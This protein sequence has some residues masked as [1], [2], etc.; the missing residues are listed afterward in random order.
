MHLGIE[1][2]HKRD[3]LTL[4]INPTERF[5]K[6]HFWKSCSGLAVFHQFHQH[7]TLKT[8]YG[9]LFPC[10]GGCFWNT[11]NIPYNVRSKIWYGLTRLR[12]AISS[13][14]L[15]TP[16]TATQTWNALRNNQ[17]PL[18]ADLLVGWG[19]HIE[20]KQGLLHSQIKDLIRFGQD[21]FS[22]FGSGVAV[23]QQSHQDATSKTRYGR[24]FLCVGGSFWNTN[25]ISYH[26]RSTF[27]SGF[28]KLRKN[29]SDLGYAL[30][31]L[32][33]RCCN[34]ET[35]YCSCFL[36]TWALS[37]NINKTSWHLGS[38]LQSGFQNLGFDNF[39]VI[40]QVCTI[41]IKVQHWKRAMGDRS[42]VL[43]G[44]YGTQT[45]SPTMSNQRS[46]MVWR[47]W[48]THFAC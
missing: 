37:N 39:A 3:F 44:V 22:K 15:G 17:I 30:F 19:V 38:T 20:H 24:P 46:D 35:R 12:Y 16:G 1:F 32:E 40:L 42:F 31:N 9:R 45:T 18:W 4:R 34:L 36:C 28:R 7:A 8:R 47:S 23:L 29:S 27:Q 43:G 10:V 6:L 26:V 48:H 14:L 41:C 5:S 11:N 21:Q 33:E 25:N 13:F 2:Q